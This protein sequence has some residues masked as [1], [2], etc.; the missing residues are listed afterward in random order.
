MT[1]EQQASQ[2]SHGHDDHEG[3]F[4]A[5]LTKVFAATTSVLLVLLLLATFKKGSAPFPANK[6]A[7]E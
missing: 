4:A 2:H 6:E 7:H 5:P 1:K 3:A